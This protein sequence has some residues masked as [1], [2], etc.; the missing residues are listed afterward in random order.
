MLKSAF[1]H[2]LLGIMIIL[3]QLAVI[4]LGLWNISYSAGAGT[5]AFYT[6]LTFVGI[7]AV[8]VIIFYWHWYVTVNRAAADLYNSREKRRAAYRRIPAN[9]IPSVVICGLVTGAAFA[10]TLFHVIF[11]DISPL[12]CWSSFLAELIAGN[13]TLLVLML[14]PGLPDRVLNKY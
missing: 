10:A 3:A 5:E 12:Y 13:V 4:V 6:G 7:Q 11:V 1:R 14:Y 2:M 8:V 9:L